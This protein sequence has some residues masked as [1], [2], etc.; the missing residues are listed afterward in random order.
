MDYYCLEGEVNI[1]KIPT[2]KPERAPHAFELLAPA[3][4]TWP[5]CIFHKI[6]QADLTLTERHLC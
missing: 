6:K 2:S 1:E 3:N 5:T 4:L